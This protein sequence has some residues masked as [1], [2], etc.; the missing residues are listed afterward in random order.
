MKIEYETGLDAYEKENKKKISKPKTKPLMKLKDGNIQIVVWN[1]EKGKVIEIKRIYKNKKGEWQETN[2]FWKKD[3][4]KLSLL[5]Q[6]T[7]KIL[8]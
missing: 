4:L 7:Y 3:L 1:N 5:L 6:E 8:K 2:K